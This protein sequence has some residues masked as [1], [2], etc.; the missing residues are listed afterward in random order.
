[1]TLNVAKE[2]AELRRMSVA[3]LRSRY[4][5]VFGEPTNAR[6]KDWLVKRVIWRMQCLA[7]G[8]IS[9]RAR[10]RAAEL[11][12]DADLR[13]RPPKAPTA[14]PQTPTRT[15]RTRLRTSG[16][17]QAPLPGTVLTRVYKGE[18]LQV[19]VLPAGFEFEGEVYK[20]L[21]AVAKKITGSH[22]NG[23]LFFRLTGNG[24]DR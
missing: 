23:Y 11:A 14:T 16:K 8:D 24:G 3:D 7:E 9:E 22:C 1:M 21:S 20:S 2:L 6:H 19:K 10:A 4:A 17:S 5:E 18:T 15:R 13:R 12:N